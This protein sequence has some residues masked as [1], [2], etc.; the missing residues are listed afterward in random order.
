MPFLAYIQIDS[1][2]SIDSATFLC[3]GENQ[4]RRLIIPVYT[5]LTTLSQASAAIREDYPDLTRIEDLIY[6]SCMVMARARVFYMSLSL[7]IYIYIYMHTY[8]MYMSCF[9]CNS[10][11]C[12]RAVPWKSA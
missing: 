9:L 5:I 4:P 10:S 12:F 2:R 11:S 3:P 6:D 1:P 7:S 8:D